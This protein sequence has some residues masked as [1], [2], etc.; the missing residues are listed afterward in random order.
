MFFGRYCSNSAS[1]VSTRRSAGVLKWHEPDGSKRFLGNHLA[2]FR[3]RVCSGIRPRPPPAL[4]YASSRREDPEIL[5]CP[6]CGCPNSESTALEVVFEITKRE[7][8]DREHF[9]MIAWSAG[10]HR[11]NDRQSKKVVMTKRKSTWQSAKRLPRLAL[12]SR[13]THLRCVWYRLSANSRK[14]DER[15]RV[16]GQHRLSEG[17]EYLG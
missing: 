14:P 13:F 8:N 12:A 11:T 4:A 17:I 5:D 2:I 6:L 7:A 1:A 10:A 9:G 16:H 3:R 15:F